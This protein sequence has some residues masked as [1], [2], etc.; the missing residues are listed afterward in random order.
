MV[1]ETRLGG[2]SLTSPKPGR[3]RAILDAATELFAER[4]FA[5]VSVQ[6]IADAAQTHKTTVLYHFDTKEALYTTVIDEALGRIADVM[7]EFLAGGFDAD[8]LRER[9]A[10]L[11]DQI[12][13]YFAEHPA[14]A[15]L[16]ERELL[17][18]AVANTYL[19]H[20]VERI[21][22]PAVAG[23]EEAVARGFI[24]PVDPAL[25]IHDLH[26]QLIGYFC[27][28]PLLERLKPG[29]PLSIDALIAR[30]NHIVDQIFSQ[31]RPGE[32]A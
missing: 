29:D 5:G 23:L 11:L 4:G 10:Y 12:H 8:H 24:R 6:E 25:F 9:V 14:H 18:E 1:G 30:R 32:V 13:A 20:F 27:H 15:R 26:V 31:L 22:Q 7:R 19:A 3:R 17:E 16:L 28:R 21:Y 2:E